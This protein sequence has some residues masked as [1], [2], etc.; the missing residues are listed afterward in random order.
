MDIIDCFSID[1]IR[2]SGAVFDI[3]K[4]RWFNQEYIKTTDSDKLLSLV[5]PLIPDTWDITPPMIDLVKESAETLNDF[6]DKVSIFFEYTPLEVETNNSLFPLEIYN[7]LNSI[8]IALQ[9]SDETTSETF[10]TVINELKSTNNLSI[11]VW[12]PIR[13]AL[14]GHEHGPDIGKVAEILG[15]DHCSLRIN[16]FLEINVH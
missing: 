16:K 13:I 14:T 1:R 7:F 15:N 4:L 3:K 12:K 11:N 10:K 2:S 5:R 8:H 9:S 6:K